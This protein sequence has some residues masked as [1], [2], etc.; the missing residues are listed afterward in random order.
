MSKTDGAATPTLRLLPL[1]VAFAAAF[2]AFVAAGFVR[3]TA[4][5]LARALAQANVPLP[6][7]LAFELAHPTALAAGLVVAGL[8]V[9]ALTRIPTTGAAGRRLPAIAFAALV[10]LF[11]IGLVLAGEGSLRLAAATA[12]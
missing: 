7:I 12:R 10:A 9:L 6:A 4:T 3:A 8:A 5:S 11:A 1:P 2:I